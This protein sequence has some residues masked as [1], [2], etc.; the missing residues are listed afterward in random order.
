MQQHVSYISL[1]HPQTKAGKIIWALVVVCCFIGAGYL[2]NKSYSDWSTSPIATTISTHGIADL[3]FP[4]L[5]VCPPKGSHTALNYDLMKAHKD[6]L[7]LKDREFL[8]NYIFDIFIKLSH[9]DYIDIMLATANKANVR[10]IYNGYQSF[11]RPDESNRIQIKVSNN[12]GQIQ[13]PFL[14]QTDMKTSFYKENHH[15]SFIFELPENIE[16]TLGGRS[17]VIQ[18]DVSTRE[19]EG[20]QEEVV[21]T[22]YPKYKLFREKKTWANAEAHCQSEGGHLASVPSDKNQGLGPL[23]WAGETWLG[24]T[25]QLSENDWKWSDG[26]IWESWVYTTCVGDISA[27]W[28]NP[29]ELEWGNWKANFPNGKYEHNCLTVN[30]GLLRDSMCT[31]KKM[32]ICKWEPQTYRGVQKHVMIYK[33]DLLPFTSLEIMYKY[34][35]TRQD[36]LDSWVDRRMTGATLTW[37]LEPAPLATSVSKVGRSIKTPGFGETFYAALMKSDLS[38]TTNLLF[39]KVSE[40]VGSGQKLVIKLE[41]DTIERHGLNLNEKVVVD[42]V[43]FGKRRL[44][45]FREKKMWVDAE[46][47]CQDIGGNLASI[48][49]ELEQQEVMDV[50]EEDV[51]WIGGNDRASEGTWEWTD[52]SPWD[53]TTYVNWWEGKGNDGDLSNCV[54]MFAGFWHDTYCTESI[55]F[56]CQVSW[57][58]DSYTMTGNTNSTVKYTK[59]ELGMSSFK[60]KVCYQ[61]DLNNQKH[62]DNSTHKKMRGYRLSSFLQDSNGTRLSEVES[63]SP[64]EWKPT[65]AEEAKYRNVYLVRMVELASL[66]RDNNITRAQIVNQTIVEKTNMVLRGTI[67]FTGDF[68][69]GSQVKETKYG[70]LFSGITLGL[71]DRRKPQIT[72]EDI[73]TG[74][75]MFSVM[76]YCSESSMKIY[77][78]LHSL[79]STKSPRTI[80]QA[81]VNTIQSNNIREEANRRRLNQFYLA[82][83]KIFDFHLGKILLA[84]SSLTELK[85]M[86]AKDWP[87]FSHYSQEI[88]MCLN[89]ASCQGIMD[90]VKTLGNM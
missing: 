24:G 26:S 32:F 71:K 75:M 58:I 34:N 63:D 7:T 76:V 20:W 82:L 4:T 84:V 5:T 81:T 36:L 11:P 29:C 66:A 21:V 25:D 22:K 88:D 31:D 9:E 83:D 19:E 72:E 3:D 41:V 54:S 14:N 13:T 61:N 70:S 39:N 86:M 48:K 45:L 65:N 80:I 74:F 59:E 16:E 10:Q 78:F 90:L 57:Y 28:K 50:A 35:Y 23:V 79:L 17:L 6:S 27:P 42:Y 52:G 40:V 55:N 2:I 15:V 77:Q 69:S 56:I 8:K 89:G 1:K 49:T 47:Y 68:C 73:E 18:L 51:V 12:Y 87:Y 85:S 62:P 44:I 30:K 53:Y 64:S 33:K 43:K 46:A 37:E 60:F 67:A 38:Y